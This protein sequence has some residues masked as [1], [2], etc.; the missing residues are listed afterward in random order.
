MRRYIETRSDIT[1]FIFVFVFAFGY[2]LLGSFSSLLYPIS[3]PMINQRGLVIILVYEVFAFGLIWPI[4]SIR[5]WSFNSIGLKPS[6]KDTFIGFI[7]YVLMVIL[8]FVPVMIVITIFAPL[9]NVFFENTQLVD[10]NINI[11]LIIFVSVI[12]P[13]FE[14][15][16]VCAYVVEKIKKHKGLAYGVMVSVLI[17]TSYHLYQGLAGMF[18]IVPMGIIF[19]L[20]YGKTRRLWPLIV[21]HGLMDLVGLLVSQ[22]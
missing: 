9:R 10:P 15:I 20:W 12:N 21:A 6:I 3:G 13:I 11:F 7:F 18:L 16:F 14:E 22:I 4:L 17:R 1:E 2:F 19:A 5:N 8:Y